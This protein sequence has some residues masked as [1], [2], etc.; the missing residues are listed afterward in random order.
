MNTNL[1]TLAAAIKNAANLRDLL[2]SLREFEDA[3][4]PRDEYGYTDTTAEEALGRLGVDLCELP[5]W[6]AW[7]HDTQG[8]WSWSPTE[9]L[10]GSGPFSDWVISPRSD[11]GG[12]A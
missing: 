1:T 10:E 12:N 11:I 6:G 9:T 2:A 4:P 7:P 5:S 3:L 8:V